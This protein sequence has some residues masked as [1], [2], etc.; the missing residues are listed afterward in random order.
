MFRNLVDNEPR[1]PTLLHYVP[2][3]C[4]IQGLKAR[5]LLIT[6]CALTTLTKAREAM[7]DRLLPTLIIHHTWILS[8]CESVCL[9]Q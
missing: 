2:R 7:G 6:F 9:F 3:F 4:L 5:N 8:R 1:A